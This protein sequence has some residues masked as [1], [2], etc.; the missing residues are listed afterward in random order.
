MNKSSKPVGIYKHYCKTVRLN[1]KLKQHEIGKILGISRQSVGNIERGVYN[2]SLEIF[3]Q[4]KQINLFSQSRFGILIEAV[5]EDFV[6]PIENRYPKSLS[7]NTNELYSLPYPSETLLDHNTINPSLPYIIVVGCIGVGK[8][9]YINSM[10]QYDKFNQYLEI[11]RLDVLPV[12]IRQQAYK[13]IEIREIDLKHKEVVKFEFEFIKRLVE[14]RYAHSQRLD[15]Y[16]K[17]LQMELG[18]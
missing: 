7:H 14:K 17:T 2:P 3:L 13:I 10:K 9:L 11:P 6:K 4:Y 18:L 8:T 15:T 16:L 5:P 1:A 12:K